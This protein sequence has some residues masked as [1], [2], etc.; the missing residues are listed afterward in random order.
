[1]PW[2]I[3]LFHTKIATLVPNV[4]AKKH[5]VFSIQVIISDAKK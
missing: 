4:D 1:M 3:L 5:K 2:P